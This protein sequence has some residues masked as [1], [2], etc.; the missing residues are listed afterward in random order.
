[1]K[2][3]RMVLLVDLVARDLQAVAHQAA[4]ARRVVVEAAAVVGPLEVLVAVAQVAVVEGVLADCP[5]TL[6]PITQTPGRPAL[7]PSKSYCNTCRIWSERGSPPF[8]RGSCGVI[9]WLGS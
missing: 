8:H 6:T 3:M 2:M 9:K 4:V 5:M 1:M 7:T